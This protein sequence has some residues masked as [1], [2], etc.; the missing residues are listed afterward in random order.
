[1]SIIFLFFS[2]NDLNTNI[3]NNIKV[4]SGANK[5]ASLPTFNY[6]KGMPKKVTWR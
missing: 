3:F 4:E 5:N 6:L 1:M 2:K